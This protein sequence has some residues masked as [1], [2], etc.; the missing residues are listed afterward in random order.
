MTHSSADIASRCTN[1]CVRC[2]RVARDIVVVVVHGGADVDTIILWFGLSFGTV[3]TGRIERFM[4]NLE[5]D[6]LLWVPCERLARALLEE[7]VVET[8]VV[9]E[10]ITPPL[11]A[12]DFREMHSVG[13]FLNHDLDDVSSNHASKLAFGTAYLALRDHIPELLKGI[14]TGE[15]S[16]HSN[17]SDGVRWVLRG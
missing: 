4:D 17:N 13:R 11:L 3:V 2:W 10:E 9:F 5:Q 14:S 7:L 6:A 8:R 16:S 12:W 15:S 1:R